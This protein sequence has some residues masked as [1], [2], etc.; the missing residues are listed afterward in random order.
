MSKNKPKKIK[1]KLLKLLKS[2]RNQIKILPPKY[3]NK[4]F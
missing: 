2:L 3:W 4:Q 1:K